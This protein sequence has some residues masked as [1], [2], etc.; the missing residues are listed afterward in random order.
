MDAFIDPITRDYVLQDGSPKRDVAG[1]LSNAIY[2]RLMTPLGSY[3]RDATLGSRLHELQRM[4]DLSRVGILAKQYAESALQPLLDDGRVTELNI[5]TEQ[6]H[7]SRL[8]L[9]IQVTGADNNVLN[10]KHP[11]KVTP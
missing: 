2:I 3:W 5:S 7:N 11:V 1:G 9:L 8:S 4:K 10:F 6:L